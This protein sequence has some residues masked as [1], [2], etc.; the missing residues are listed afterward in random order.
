MEQFTKENGKVTKG[1][2][3]GP[4]SG[5]TEQNMMDSGRTIKHMGGAYSIMWMA[6]YLMVIG[7]TTKPMGM[8]SISMLMAQLTRDTGRMTCNRDT[9]SRPGSTRAVTM[10]RMWV[11][12]R[13]A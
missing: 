4:R 8:G 1:M 6:T 11:G 2:V 7:P 9:A 3:M 12:R 13:R 5:Q 10:A